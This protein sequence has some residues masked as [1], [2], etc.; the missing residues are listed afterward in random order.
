[1]LGLA[2]PPP[3]RIDRLLGELGGNAADTPDARRRFRDFV[4]DA[5]PSTPSVA[6]AIRS[7]QRVVGDEAFVRQVH[8]L[9][10]E[11]HHR[12]HP[13]RDWNLWRPTL[14]QLFSRH[15][16][17]TL[18]ETVR[19]ACVIHGYKLREIALAL[20]VHYSTV[21]RLLRRAE[22][23]SSAPGGQVLQ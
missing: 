20:G 8:T 4:E 23:R 2:D 10:V 16:P 18:P 15:R 17:D 1:M 11:S 21:S 3:F 19:T 7:D 5:R 9:A 22:S 6:H 14:P 12:E 13:A